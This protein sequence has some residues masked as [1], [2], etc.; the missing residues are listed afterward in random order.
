[1]SV[2]V[3]LIL[4]IG[5]VALLLLFVFTAM[6]VFQI[7]NAA[8]Q[9]RDRKQLSSS[10][11]RPLKE[12]N[13]LDGNSALRLTGPVVNH[14]ISR[15]QYLVHKFARSCARRRKPLAGGDELPSA[16]EYGV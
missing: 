11:V 6:A 1:M 16:S 8:W 10:G 5:V 7:R 15:G 4:T 14:G 9:I 12:G 2:I 3:G 13:S